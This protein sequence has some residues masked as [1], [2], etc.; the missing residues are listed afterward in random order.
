M[1]IKIY[2]T[3]FTGGQRI[4]LRTS[5]AI[6][7]VTMIKDNNRMAGRDAGRKVSVKKEM[8]YL[9]FREGDAICEVEVTPSNMALVGAL[10]DSGQV[11]L[12]EPDFDQQYVD[13][14]KVEVIEEADYTEVKEKVEK[15]TLAKPKKSRAASAKK[16]AATRKRNAEAKKAKEEEEL[17]NA[18]ETDAIEV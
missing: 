5:T 15:A 2:Y 8:P 16:A 1:I 14:Y 10:I 13:K 3:G 11:A 7:S 18:K 17:K 6:E 9:V 4:K 12:E